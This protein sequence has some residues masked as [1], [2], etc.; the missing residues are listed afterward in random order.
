[1]A[2]KKKGYKKG[3]AVKKMGG[4]RM[5]KPVAMK[6]GSKIKKKTMSRGGAVKKRYGGS[7]KKKTMAKGGKT[8]R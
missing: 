8:R 4:G 2:M 7:M 3:G 5:K 1:M 6:K